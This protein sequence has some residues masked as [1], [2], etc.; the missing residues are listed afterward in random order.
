MKKYSVTLT[1]DELS[2]L[3]DALSAKDEDIENARECGDYTADEAAEATAGN[4]DA[5]AALN[6][7]AEVPDETPPAVDATP[8]PDDIGEIIS[9]GDSDDDGRG[10]CITIERTLSRGVW[11]KAADDDAARTKAERINAYIQ[12]HPGEIEDAGEHW[13]YAL[14]D[15][16]TGRTVKPWT[17]N[18]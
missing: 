17:N 15:T 11:F 16:Q 8:P 1:E 5:R 18:T 10:Y 12:E 9:D 4:A 7:A 13:D 14:D 3:Y 2:R 6:A